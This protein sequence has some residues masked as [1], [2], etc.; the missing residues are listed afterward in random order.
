[1][2]FTKLFHK[3]LNKKEK[4]IAASSTTKQNLWGWNLI[5]RI[6]RRKKVWFTEGK[7]AM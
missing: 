2:K 1:M 6:V 5:S 3:V 4:I 7:K